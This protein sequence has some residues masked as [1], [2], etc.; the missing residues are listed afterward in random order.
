MIYKAYLTFSLEE[1]CNEVFIGD[2]NTEAEA[3]IAARVEHQ[4]LGYRTE[5]YARI[6]FQPHGNFYDVG[7]HCHFI[8]VIPVSN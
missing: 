8:A 6:L 7:S 3:F 5:P 2:F 1:L 4:K